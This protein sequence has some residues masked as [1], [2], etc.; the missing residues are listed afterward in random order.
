MIDTSEVLNCF[1]ADWGETVIVGGEDMDVVVEEPGE[2]ISPLT[3]EIVTTAPQISGPTSVLE[4]IAQGTEVIRKGVTYYV[5]GPPK[6]GGLSGTTRI[7]S[8]DP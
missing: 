7:L 3:G 8:K 5:I 1:V 4:S 6:S 2:T